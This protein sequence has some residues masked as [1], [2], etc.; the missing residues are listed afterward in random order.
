LQERFIKPLSFGGPCPSPSFPGI[1]EFFRDFI[2]VASCPML[3]QHLCD[4][5][6]AKVLELNETS[7]THHDEEDAP[8]SNGDDEV[9][10][11][12]GNLKEGG[13]DNVQGT[14][15]LQGKLMNF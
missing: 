15:N 7:F 3:N 8:T 1:Q 14:G 11:S 13:Y 4:T 2:A 12:G 5:F 10:N 9:M 6:S